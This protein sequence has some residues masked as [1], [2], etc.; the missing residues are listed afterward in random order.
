[1]KRRTFCLIAVFVLLSAVPALAEDFIFRDNHG[2]KGLQDTCK[3]LGCEVKKSLDGDSDRLF[4]VK[5]PRTNDA[6]AFMDLLVTVEGGSYEPNLPFNVGEPYAIAGQPPAALLDHLE[7]PYFNTTVWH[8]YVTQPPAGRISLSAAQDIV[9]EQTTREAGNGIVAVIDTGIDPNHPA[10]NGLLVTGYDFIRNQL[11]W[12]SETSD[13]DVDQSTMAVLDN[14][15]PVRVNQ[16]TM[17]VLDENLRSKLLG[18]PMDI[19]AFGHGTMVAGI[20]H[21]AAPTA[22]IM[23][24]KVFQANGTGYLSDVIRAINWA[25]AHKADVINM[26]FSYPEY[27]NELMKAVSSANR[28]GVICVA[29]AGNRGNATLVYPAAL[30]KQV[31]G[32]ASTTMDTDPSLDDKLSTFSNRGA[33]LVWVGAPGEGIVTPYPFGT[34]AA[35]W[36]TSFSTPFV[37]G[38]AALLRSVD[39]SLDQSQ[40]AEAIGSSAIPVYPEMGHGRLD[41]SVAVQAWLAASSGATPSNRKNH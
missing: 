1:M 37:S 22:K 5:T 28:K 16:S 32:V 4:L 35:G 8:G 25:V 23:S 7:M 20:V 24:L 41:V 6:K 2:L 13:L 33:A 34:Y 17:A 27:S 29:A 18:Q 26:S 9:I 14:A 39:D 19:S 38:T 21:L 15:G 3:R 40:A 10:F 30:Q 12:G 11:G 36:G 31:M